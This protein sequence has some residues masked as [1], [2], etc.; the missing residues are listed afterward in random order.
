MR[1]LRQ[2][3]RV[4]ALAIALAACGGADARDDA[5]P[6][7]ESA[8]P[9]ATVDAPSAAAAADP[10]ARAAGTARVSLTGDGVSVAGEFPAT[11]C[12]GPYILGKGMSYQTQ[13]GDW[14]ITVASETRQSGDV[15]LNANASDVSVVA[16]ANG[17]G[18][19]LVRGPRNGGSLRV[20]DDFKQAEADLELR[21]LMGRETARLVVTFHCG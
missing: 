7:A 13:A 14:K 5:A 4:G 17:P 12:G 18:K 8:A 21:S 16:T 3:L 20:T 6:E 2:P 11:A 9:E 15:P 10:V 1:L 19:Q